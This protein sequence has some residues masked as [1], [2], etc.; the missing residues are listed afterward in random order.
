MEAAIGREINPP[1]WA[2]TPPIADPPAIPR[3]DATGFNDAARSFDLGEYCL[4][5]SIK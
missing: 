4:A 1:C 5:K 2:T 3:L